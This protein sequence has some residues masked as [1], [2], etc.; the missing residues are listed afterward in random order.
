[1]S[2][3]H[4][5]VYGDQPVS[6]RAA[7]KQEVIRVLVDVRQNIGIQAG[8]D[9]EDVVTAD[10]RGVSIAHAATEQGQVGL[11]AGKAFTPPSGNCLDIGGQATLRIL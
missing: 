11:E 4:I 6:G 2:P 1:M 8:T 5:H 7:T 10:L 3:T 9:G